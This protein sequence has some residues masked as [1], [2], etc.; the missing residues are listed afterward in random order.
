MIYK[1]TLFI[2]LIAL[3]AVSNVLATI[4]CTNPKTECVE[5]RST[6]DYEGVPV[7]LDCWHTRT[8]SECKETADNNCQ[9]LR[10]QGCSQVGVKCKVMFNDTC[11]VQDE[12]YRCPVNKCSAPITHPKELFCKEGRCTP[13]SPQQDKNFNK[14]VSSFAALLEV[15]DDIKK[16]HT[17]NPEIFKG[18]ALECSRNIL[19]GITKDCCADNEGIFRC[20][21]GEKKLFQ[22]RKAGL[23]IEVGEYCHNKD[24][25]TKL[26][27]SHHTTYC[28]FGSRIAKI[29]QNDGRRNQLGI[30]FGHVSDDSGAAHVDCRGLTK[31]ELAR[32]DFSKMDFSEIY[33]EIKAKAEEKMPPKETLKQ[34]VQGVPY[35]ELRDRVLKGKNVPEETGL[36]LKAAERI[37]E[38]YSDRTKK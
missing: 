11:V 35:E 9:A 34:K 18:G 24:P 7:T 1:P 32:M 27:T 29:I 5:G 28:T 23:A 14:A 16:Q 25:I 3:V 22:M 19:P 15:S 12:T 2:P 33:K 13:T 4:S 36:G 37:K 21:E 20:D 10:D 8:I 30:G 26:C 31:D 38:F 17:E 6:K